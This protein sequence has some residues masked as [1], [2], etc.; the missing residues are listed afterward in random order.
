MLLVSVVSGRS[1]DALRNA[2]SVDT[3]LAQPPPST[4][5]PTPD[6][7]HLGPVQVSAGLYAGFEFNDN[8]NGSQLDPKADVLLRGGTSLALA[9]PATERSELQFDAGL[10][11]LHY[12]SHPEYG[13]LE[14]TPNSALVWEIGLPDGTL[15]FYDQLSYAEQVSQEATI[16]NVVTLPRLDNVIGARLDWEPGPW[17]VE[18]SYG[19]DTYFSPQSAYQYLNHSSEYFFARGGR[20][21]ADV[22]QFGL[23]ASATLTAYDLSYQSDNRSLSAGA[24]LEWQVTQN[25]HASLRAGPTIY[26]F[27]SSGAAGPQPDLRSY[28]LVFNVSDTLT[29]FLSQQLSLEREVSLGLNLGGGYVEQL[30]ASYALSLALTSHIHLGANVAYEQ[31]NQP[32]LFP[33]TGFP[34]LLISEVEN[35]NRAGWGATIAWDFTDHFSTSVHYGFWRRESSLPGLG[36][37]QN[38]IALQVTYTF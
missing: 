18:G 33:V 2:L 23:E 30:T 34:G 24:Y 36:Y 6:R 9:W 4:L 28:Y 29:S 38:S 3:V 16:A 25:L 20:K 35:Y 21:L 12:W 37:T 11:Y 22:T 26:Q 31:G 14:V 15:S 8:I 32:L 17:V 19:H 1:Q 13:G 27:T 5:T 7:P 10:G